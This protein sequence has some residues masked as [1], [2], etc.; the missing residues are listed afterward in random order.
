MPL[1]MITMKV[2]THTHSVPLLSA[3]WAHNVGAIYISPDPVLYFGAE[4]VA[5][6]PVSADVQPCIHVAQLQ[7]IE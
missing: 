4:T 6:S 3:G 2:H 1:D 7:P 5:A